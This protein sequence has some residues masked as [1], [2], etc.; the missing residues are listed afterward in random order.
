M[1]KSQAEVVADQRLVVAKL[2]NELSVAKETLQWM[3]MD[4]RGTVLRSYDWDIKRLGPN[5]ATQK[6]HLDYEVD[7]IIRDYLKATGTEM[8][9]VGQRNRVSGLTDKLNIAR[10]TLQGAIDILDDQHKRERNAVW[11]ELTSRLDGD[12]IKGLMSKG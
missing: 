7:K 8:E 5:E 1:N 10:A 6:L 3:E 12:E 4:I 2:E 9:I 11:Q